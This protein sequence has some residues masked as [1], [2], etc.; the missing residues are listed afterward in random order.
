M[1]GFY[2]ELLLCERDGVR[3]VVGVPAMA[4]RSGSA[5]RGRH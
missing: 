2:G 4:T 1:A 3:H 5:S